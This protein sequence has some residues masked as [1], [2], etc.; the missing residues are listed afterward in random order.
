VLDAGPAGSRNSLL[1]K[2]SRFGSLVG[3]HISRYRDLQ[4]IY[5]LVL[6]NA[7]EPSIS[8]LYSHKY[9][10]AEACA[11]RT[12]TR[13]G[14]ELPATVSDQPVKCCPNRRLTPCRGRERTVETR[15]RTCESGLVCVSHKTL[16]VSRR[17]YLTLFSRM[18][19]PQLRMQRTGA[20]MRRQYKL[21]S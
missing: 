16:V 1:Y 20:S 18:H 2:A 7:I 10:T 19:R 15:S 21:A 9:S 14:W 17:R 5:E 4:I 6:S 8:P 13:S 3:I 11:R 12:T